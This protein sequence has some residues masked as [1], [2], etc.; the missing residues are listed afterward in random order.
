MHIKINGK[1]HDIESGCTI[2]R[3]LE[4]LNLK[5][6]Q[7]AVEHNRNIVLRSDFESTE[8]HGDDQVEIV[9]FVGGG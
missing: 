1:E 6:D 7:V 5:A 8:L 3:L 2:A 9:N 4:L